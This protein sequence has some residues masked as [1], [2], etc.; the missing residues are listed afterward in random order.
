MRRRITG[1]LAALLAEAEPARTGALLITGGDTLLAC[2]DRLGGQG[3]EPLLE[4]FPGVVLSRFQANGRTRL[5]I[6]KSGGFGEETLLT[7]LKA[8]IEG[9][10]NG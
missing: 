10:T 2:L 1:S 5:V 3:L 7:D 4:L 6:S 9:Q 8:L